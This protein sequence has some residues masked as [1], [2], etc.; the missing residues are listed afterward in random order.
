MTQDSEQYCVLNSPLSSIRL[1]IV[2]F[3]PC[4]GCLT[5]MAC[6][7]YD[8]GFI[9]FPKLFVDDC[10]GLLRKGHYEQ[11]DNGGYLML[12]LH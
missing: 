7:E 1:G 2:V 10:S 6:R 4:Q 3:L 12:R 9:I 11:S 5:A 8:D